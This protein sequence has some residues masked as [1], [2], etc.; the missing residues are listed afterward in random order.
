M[1]DSQGGCHIVALYIVMHASYHG[2]SYKSALD[3]GLCVRL[4]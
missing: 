2:L 1:T 4:S 3:V